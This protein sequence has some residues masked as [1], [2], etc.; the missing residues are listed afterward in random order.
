MCICVCV[1]VIQ[2]DALLPANLGIE[3]YSLCDLVELQKGVLV[4]QMQESHAS[5]SRHIKECLVCNMC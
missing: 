1:C 2:L 3:F 4:K 5:F